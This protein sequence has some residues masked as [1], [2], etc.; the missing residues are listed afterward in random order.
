MDSQ[1][2]ITNPAT[3]QE[4]T[5]K[6]TNTREVVDAINMMS[7]TVRH[8]SEILKSIPL[9]MRC[10]EF[11][12]IDR[13]WNTKCLLADANAELMMPVNNEGQRPTR[14]EGGLTVP[15]TLSEL[16]AMSES[17]LDLLLDFYERPYENSLV[18]IPSKMRV[19]KFYLGVPQP[20]LD[21]HHL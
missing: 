11:R 14:G 8:M 5:L 17:D 4:E 15:R 2:N 6:L 19:L 9:I 16:H 21:Q 13:N 18:D 7:R 12:Q 1:V 3:P 10:S 20:Y